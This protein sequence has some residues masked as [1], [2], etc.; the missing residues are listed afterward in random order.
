MVNIQKKS[1]DS[2]MSLSGLIA[3]IFYFLHVF[4]GQNI[5]TN[6][7]WL[8][9][10]VS[11]LTA[12][13]SVSYYEASK[14]SSLYGMFS[15]ICCLFLLRK[16]KNTNKQ[17]FIGIIL[18]TI[19]NFISTI[20]YTL[21]PLSGSGFAGTF[22]DIMHFYIVTMSVVLLSI[23]SILFF[24]FGSFKKNGNIL[25]GVI[26]ILC[27]SLMF[28]GSVSMNIF[29]RSYFGLLERFSVF[30]IVIYT[31]ILGLWGFIIDDSLI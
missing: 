15:C 17:I 28:F 12:V 13:N 21:F 26:S 2:V 9:Q 30:S 31:G 3:L 1:F 22:Q 16:F 25:I 23:I 18:Y 6:Y 11:D 10:A 4:I 14:Y 29:P 24:I 19:M 7:N 8:S 27:L 20:G 5:Y